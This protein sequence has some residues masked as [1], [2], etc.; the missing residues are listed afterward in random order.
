MRGRLGG[1][2]PRDERYYE[3]REGVRARV[4]AR[5]RAAHQYAMSQIAMVFDGFEA[6]A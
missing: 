4:I 6:F 3:R 2:T 5:E 1:E